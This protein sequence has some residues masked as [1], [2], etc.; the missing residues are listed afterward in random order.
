MRF[1]CDGEL[2]WIN[3]GLE[4]RGLGISSKLLQQLAEWFISQKAFYICVDCA[5]GNTIGQRFYKRHAAENLNEH[6]LIWKDISVLFGDIN[7]I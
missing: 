6:W 4:Y 3:V 2:Q 5:P 7:P 1:G